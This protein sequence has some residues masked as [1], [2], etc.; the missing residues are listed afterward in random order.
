MQI[1]LD[2]GSATNRILGY[3][4]GFVV[5]N[6]ERFD[7]S[8]IVMPETLVTDWSPQTTEDL[9]AEH[10]KTIVDLNPELIVLGTGERQIFPESSVL[11]PLIDRGTG[12]EIMDTRA[13]CRTYNILMAEG[14]IVAAAL[15]MTHR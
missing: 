10:L 3:G 14:R 11:R 2:P 9:V 8:V 6:E 5:V 4:D 12:F 15:L 13:A 1:S 7:A